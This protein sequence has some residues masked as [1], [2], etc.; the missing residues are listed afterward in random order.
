MSNK[1]FKIIFVTLLII[2]ALAPGATSYI[3]DE[4]QARENARIEQ[5]RLKAEKIAAEK[6][7]LTG[8]FDQL[9]REDFVA[10]DNKYI[11]GV[12][13]MYLRKEAYQAFLDMAA[14]AAK[15]GVT[16]QIASA[17]RNFDY[18]K[19]LWN[20]KW[21]GRTLVN[22]KDLSKSI[23]DGLNRFKKILEYSAA[24]STSRHHWGTDI[25][26]NNANVEYFDTTYGK[27]VY[28]WLVIN[29]PSYGFCQPYNEKGVERLEG[30]N[31]EKWHWSYTPL[32]KTFTQRYEE[33]I[34][35]ADIFDFSGD[36][37]VP[38]LNLIKNYVLAINPECL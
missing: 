7:Y 3:H 30:Y 37:F 15:D 33:L 23:P 38:D 1:S 17:T 32:A 20:K 13:P 29:A 28:I 19:N 22:G 9:K 4:M 18:Q 31:E 14:A 6:I 5:V 12:S 36:T 11:L 21:D 16:L 35:T 24:P 10:I 2:I 26:I 34:T 8:K 25:D 27:K